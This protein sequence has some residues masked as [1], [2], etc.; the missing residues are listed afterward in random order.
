MLLSLVVFLVA[1][2][3]LLTIGRK[4]T[5]KIWVSIVV[6]VC[7]FSFL[8]AYISVTS[9][10]TPHSSTWD[11]KFSEN[12]G[13]F[14]WSKLSYPLYLGVNHTQVTWVELV[15]YGHVDFTIFLVNT[16]IARVGGTFV[17]SGGFFGPSPFYYHLDF[18][19][20]DPDTF[21]GILLILLSLLNIIGALLGV[22]L[23]RRIREVVQRRTHA[24]GLF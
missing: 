23:A 4:L 9:V 8:L 13:T 2:F 1:V 14:P 19:F 3:G 20:S 24:R 10:W 16:K 5:R 7:V 22:I 12:E 6:L 21:F 18:I 15:T 11:I 17:Y